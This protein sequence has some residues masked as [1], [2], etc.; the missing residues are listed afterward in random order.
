MAYEDVD[1]LQPRAV[2][3]QRDH[4]GQNEDEFGL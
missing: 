3:M 4:G 2:F 1:R